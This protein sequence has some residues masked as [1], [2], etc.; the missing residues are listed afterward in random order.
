M[1]V[2]HI[3]GEVTRFSAARFRTNVSTADK[4]EALQRCWS[5]VYTGMPNRISVGQTSQLVEL[6]L[7][8]PSPGGLMS[9][10]R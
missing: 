5:F 7:L 10:I 1:P 2:L 8:P 6:R 9:H 3:V 4:L